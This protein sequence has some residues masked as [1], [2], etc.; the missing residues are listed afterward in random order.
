MQ[1]QR[2]ANT[3]GRAADS[4]NQRLGKGRDF[5]QKAPHRCICPHGA[6]RAGLLEE[7]ANIVAR[8]EDGDVALEHHHAHGRIVLGCCQGAC[9]FA[10]HGF[11]EGVLLAGTVEGDG[12]NA[13]LGVHEDVLLGIAHSWA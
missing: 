12:A 4:S 13:F 1:Q 11:G 6:G 3:H 9:H 5:L 10:V 7:V 8:A 2:G